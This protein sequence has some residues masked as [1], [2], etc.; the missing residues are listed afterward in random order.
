MAKRLGKQAMTD[1]KI[2]TF[3]P[4]PPRDRRVVHLALAK[5]EGVV[6]QTV[7]VPMVQQA[8]YILSGYR[9]ADIWFAPIPL[10]DHGAGSSSVAAQHSASSAGFARSST[11]LDSGTRRQRSS[12]A[13]CTRSS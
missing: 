9:G 2:I 10:A 5:L 8:A 4:M 1:G 11:V 13:P 7:Q 6:G 3:E 12:R